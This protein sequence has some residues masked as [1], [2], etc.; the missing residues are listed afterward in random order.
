M[1]KT[2]ITH[3]IRDDFIAVGVLHTAGRLGITF[4]PGKR[5]SGIDGMWERDLGLD[6][7]RLSGHFAVDELVCLLEPHELQLLGIDDYAERVLE[8]GFHLTRFAIPDGDVPTDAAALSRCLEAVAARIARGKTIVVHCRGGL[9]RAGTVAAC[10][11]ILDGHDSQDAIAHV[12]AA[13]PGAIENRKQENFV[14]RFKTTV[15]EA[16]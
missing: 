3:P 8:A 4:A 2:S 7:E 14:A 16:P 13:R 11:L 9:G 15:K 6:L 12:R 5:A 10:L 1:L